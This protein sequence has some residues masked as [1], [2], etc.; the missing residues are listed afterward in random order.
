MTYL[1]SAGLAKPEVTQTAMNYISQGY[2][3][4]LTF[5]TPSGGFSWWGTH[6]NPQP[7]VSAYGLFQLHDTAKVYDIDPQIIKKSQDWLISIQS[8]DG[9]WGNVGNTHGEKIATFQDPRLPLTGYIAWVLAETKYSGPQLGKALDFLRKNIGDTDNIYV[10]A[11]TANALLG[12]NPDDKLGGKLIEKI[13]SS[14]TDEQDVTYWKTGSQTL[15]Y[16]HGNS[17]DIETTALV[18]NALIKSG[19]HTGVVNRSLNYI[20]KSRSSY[21]AW[22]STQATILSL[23]ALTAASSGLKPEG[24]VQ[25]AVDVNGSKR[26]LTVTPDQFDVTQLVDFRDATRTGSNAISVRMN[27]KGTFMYQIVTRYYLPWDSKND[28]QNSNGFAFDVKYDK[29]KVKKDD[30][31]TANVSMEYKGAHSTYMVVADLAVPAGFTVDSESFEKMVKDGQIMKYTNQGKN[32][33]LYFG[34]VKPGEKIKYS[35]KLTPKF[36][37]KV[38]TPVSQVYEYYA[39]DFRASTVPV[40]LEVEG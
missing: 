33:I 12:S 7:W 2:Q 24:T 3:K 5:Q 26:I 10:L 1:K 38:K 11:L 17:A 4:I 25:V 16:A 31:L 6:D 29:M 23:K 14:K 36:P 18:I 15:S 21:G 19:K 35:Y 8:A 40:E 37:I 13:V 32:V 9:S 39:P 28:K 20:V 34:D 22:G 27:G 30:Q